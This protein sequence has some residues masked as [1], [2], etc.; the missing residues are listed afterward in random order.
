M[1][2]SIHPGG[3]EL[4]MVVVKLMVIYIPWDPNPKIKQSPR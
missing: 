1:V 4:G 2:L 3:Y